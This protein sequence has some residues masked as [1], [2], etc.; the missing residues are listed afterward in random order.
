MTDVEALYPVTHHGDQPQFVTTYIENMKRTHLVG[1]GKNDLN[2]AKS[3]GLRTLILRYH[4]SSA[5]ADCGHCALASQIRFA[6][7]TR[8]Q[9]PYRILL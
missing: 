3:S 1:D 9:C 6:V 2:A 8:M 4:S 5:L 7:I